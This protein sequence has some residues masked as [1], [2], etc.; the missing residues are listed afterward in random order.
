VRFKDNTYCNLDA[1]YINY[2][3]GGVV[4]IWKG[5]NTLVAIYNLADIIG[6]CVS[7]GER[8]GVK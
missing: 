8:S 4:Q 3:E 6:V 2:T 7:G 5:D 1:D